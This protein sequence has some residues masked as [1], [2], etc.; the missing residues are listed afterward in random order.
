[1]VP[2]LP[3]RRIISRF[4][5]RAGAIGVLVGASSWRC[6][7]KNEAGFGEGRCG[8]GSDFRPQLDQL[9]V[10]RGGALCGF[11]Q[12]LDLPPKLLDTTDSQRI[13][14]GT[15]LCRHVIDGGGGM[16][17][18]VFAAGFYFCNE[19]SKFVRQTV[20]A[21]CNFLVSSTCRMNEFIRWGGWTMAI[22]R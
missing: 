12:A 4:P 17:T 16:L 15:S 7:G 13:V 10:A 3:S 18:N 2:S 8:P 20:V 9:H 5:A 11:Y 1:M 21:A 6:A 22:S 19:R 14:I